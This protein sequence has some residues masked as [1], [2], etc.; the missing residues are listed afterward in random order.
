MNLTAGAS[1]SLFGNNNQSNAFNR[2]ERTL[3]GPGAVNASSLLQT[4]LNSS[5][6]FGALGEASQQDIAAQRLGSAN[7]YNKPNEK[8]VLSQIQTLLRKWDPNSQ[9]TLIQA[10]IYNSVNSAYAPFYYRNADEP[11]KEWEEALAKKPKPIES[12][13]SRRTMGR[14]VVATTDTVQDGNNRSF[15]PVLVRGFHA[16]GSRLEYQARIVTE[17]RARLHEMNNRLDL[18]ASVAHDAYC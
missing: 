15:V 7:L 18:G 9:D 12:N 11:E 13:V 5:T 1:G 10:Y 17:M 16:L 4:G 3:D 14:L 8:N 6:G 2:S